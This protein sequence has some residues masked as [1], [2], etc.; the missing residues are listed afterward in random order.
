MSMHW[1]WITIPVSV[2]GLFAVPF[3]AWSLYVSQRDSVLVSVPLVAEQD[4]DIPDSGT[5]LLH[6]EGPRMTTVFGDLDYRLTDLS[7][8]RDVPLAMVLFR[9]KSSGLSRVRLS[10]RSFDVARPGRY[11]LT[12]TG[13][14][15]GPPP[16]RYGMAITLD[17]RGGLVGRIVALVFASIGLLAGLALSFVIYLI[18]R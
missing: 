13:L 14:R 10:L 5:M 6:A 12:V 7:D 9:Q 1:L 3:L 15:A 8:N 4:I 11:R 2:I 17:R 18:D 16:E